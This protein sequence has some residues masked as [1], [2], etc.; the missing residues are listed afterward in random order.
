MRLERPD[1]LA[2]F[3]LRTP[4]GVLVRWVAGVRSSVQRKLLTAFLLI[5]LL[6]FAMGAFSLAT[7]RAMSHQ[8]EL[9]DQAHQRVDWSQ[10]IH[11]SLAMQ[12]HLT[13]M[14][15][16][17]RQ[18][19]ALAAILR[20][21]NRFNEALARLE[22]AVEEPERAVIQK[23]RAGQEEAMTLVA[24]IA[25]LVR[26]GKIDAATRLH[27]DREDPLYR[28]IDDD[29][30]AL[31]Q[32]E[33]ARMEDLRE[34][35]R[36]ANQRAVLVVG[37]SAAICVLLALAGGF[38]ISWALIQ[39]VHAAHGFLEELA[40][41]RF[42]GLITVDNRDEFGDLAARLSATSA[43]LARLDAEQR[44]AA[45]ALAALNARLEQASKAKSEFLA[46]M[47]HEL[48]T[49]LNAI[50]GFTEMLTDELYGAVPEEFREP[51]A[52]IQT[53]G[54]HL[55]RLINDVL[56]LSKI[57][58]GRME[59]ALSEYS[60]GDVV[61]SVRTSLRSLAEERGL[62]FK[63]IVD[64]RLP[65]VM[66]GDAKRITQCLLNLAGNAIKF[67][68]QGGV[69]IRAT[70]EGDTVRYSV[71]DT[72]IGIPPDQ[73]A[74]VFAEFRQVDSTITRE[75]GGTGLGLSITKKFVEMHG[76]RIW[77]ESRLNEGSTFHF[78]IPLR[79]EAPSTV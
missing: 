49:P 46:N 27:A 71:S 57:E 3:L 8:S 77:V 58:A 11:H 7:I 20:E 53:N 54:K 10:R 48:R 12:M 17:V 18:E 36:A 44:R 50:L 73:L 38:I 68:K 28:S 47:S 4:I 66:V 19:T 63:A 5:T 52:D 39:P 29:V 79:V 9:L 65:E 34:S 72:G 40:A 21:N 16:L 59:L 78:T 6:F 22:A 13:A 62:E 24:D 75:F 23:I 37:T 60:P 35:L 1:R 33:N 15:L 45:Q 51:L 76:G 55:L 42:G 43:E 64:Q 70:C 31:V 2:A 32:K 61:N 74:S 14:A 26:D 56:D 41:G 67:T 69:T 30:S 25:N